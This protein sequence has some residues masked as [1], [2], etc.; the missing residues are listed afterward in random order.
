MIATTKLCVFYTFPWLYFLLISSVLQ[1][2]KQQNSKN[3]SWLE[4]MTFFLRH[5]RFRYQRQLST[6]MTIGSILTCAVN[7]PQMYGTKNQ[8]TKSWNE[9]RRNLESIEE[10]IRLLGREY[11]GSSEDTYSY[12]A[13]E[14]FSQNAIFDLRMLRNTSD[15]QPSTDSMHFATIN[16]ILKRSN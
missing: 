1:W 7:N 14:M 15:Y 9:P 3:R 13:T 2:Y 10:Q 4:R 12:D 5:R 8:I 16:V 11:K 6:S